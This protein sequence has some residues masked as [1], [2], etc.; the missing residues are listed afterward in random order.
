MKVRRLTHLGLL[1]AIGLILSRA[2]I[3]Q[4]P[5]AGAAAAMKPFTEKIPGSLVTFDMVPVPA[6][7]GGRPFYIA[8]TE[9]TW[10]A[11]DIF[12]F[13]L[14]L[15]QEQGANVDATSRPSKPYGAPDRGFGHKGYPAGSIPHQAAEA[16]CAWLSQKTGKKYRLPTEAEWEWV[17]TAG[18]PA[19]AA[20]LAKADLDKA[21]WYWDTTEEKTMAV[22]T[23][24]PNAW[25]VH[26]MLGNVAEWV[27]VGQGKPPVVKGGSF[28]DKAKDLYP[29]ARLPYQPAWQESDAQNPKS[30]WWYADGP[31]VGFRVVCEM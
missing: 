9:T 25:G 11:Y 16:Y 2:A 18:K 3:G 17:A 29:K 20:P 1:V 24:T 31:Q 6:P 14:D 23:K 26:D 12:A 19:A 4:T 27:T 21:A 8:K 15:T 28:L 13:R 10:D 5:A 30:K 7:P 22:G